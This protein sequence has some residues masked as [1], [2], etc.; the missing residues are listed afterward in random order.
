MTE[1]D[2]KL[3]E[4]V[5]NLRLQADKYENMAIANEKNRPNLTVK[6]CGM[7]EAY[8]EIADKIEDK[9]RDNK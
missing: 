7:A 6:L 1:L 2:L 9:F 3:Y 8:R 5:R 4:F